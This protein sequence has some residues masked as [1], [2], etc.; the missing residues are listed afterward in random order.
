MPN[1]KHYII[2]AVT[3]GCIGI[4][5]AAAI[6]LT[7]LV[8]KDKIEQNKK[9]KINQGIAEI[10]G[11]NSSILDEGEISG[12]EYTTYLYTIKQDGKENNQYAFVT[13][14]SNMY[15]KI[16]LLVGFDDLKQFKGISIITNEQTYAS[17]LV[18]KYINPLNDSLNKDSALEDVSCGATY[19]AK[20]VR[21]MVN[22]AKGV[23]AK[24]K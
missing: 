13:D 24:I 12:E 20:L 22:D 1:T 4:A 16:S 19:G 18:N 9:D 23:I 21:D 11:Q 14:G 5:S 17:T 15:G 8:T 6:G 2:T 10:F 7:N 3:L